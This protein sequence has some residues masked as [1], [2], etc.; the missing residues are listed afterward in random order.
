V[1]LI[2]RYSLKTSEN[3]IKILRGYTAICYVNLYH[4]ILN[5][6]LLTVFV[7]LMLKT[8]WAIRGKCL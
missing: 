8:F 6:I 7:A 3:K 4:I 2:V 5:Q 1:I